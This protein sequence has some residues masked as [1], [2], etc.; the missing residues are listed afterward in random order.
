MAPLVGADRHVSAPFWPP[1]RAFGRLGPDVAKTGA[2]LRRTT[3]KSGCSEIATSRPGFLGGLGIMSR[4][5]VLSAF[6]GASDV[7]GGGL[8]AISRKLALRTFAGVSS[9]FG[10][11]LRVAPH[12]LVLGAFAG[13]PAV[14]LGRFEDHLAQT[15]LACVCWRIRCL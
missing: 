3:P 4:K 7:L 5:L 6:A 10:D 11:Y 8:R 14:F 1:N 13:A 2:L 15:C 9:V 12:K